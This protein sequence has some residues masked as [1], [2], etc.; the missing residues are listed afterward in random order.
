MPQRT[1]SLLAE[2]AAGW[3][4]VLGKHDKLILERPGNTRLISVII[5]QG[6]ICSLHAESIWTWFIMICSH[7][8]RPWY[9][10]DIGYNLNSLISVII[11]SNGQF[12]HSFIYLYLFIYSLFHSP[13][14]R[15][16]CFDNHLWFH[17][18]K[19]SLFETTSKTLLFF[20]RRLNTET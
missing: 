9:H 11:I 2:V 4:T 20:G 16:H 1:G 7:L 6:E 8:P 13:N 3:K 14:G 10:G 19:K 18:S 15:K 12:V 5:S 17:L